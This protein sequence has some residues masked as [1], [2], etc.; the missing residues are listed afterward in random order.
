MI[1]VFAT[2][3]ALAGTADLAEG[4]P[5]APPAF[6]FDETE[7]ATL[8]DGGTVHRYERWNDIDGGVAAIVVDAPEDVVWKHILDYDRYV[9]FMPYVTASTLD[10]TTPGADQTVYDCSM[11]LTTKG[12]VTRYTVR[13]VHV[14]PQGYMTF[15]MLPLAGN[16]LREATGY[17]RVEPWQDDPTRT[18][19][20]YRIDIDTAWYVPAFV[21]N[22]AAD[23]GLP[24]VA[25]LIA[26]QAEK[27]VGTY[28]PE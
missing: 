18:V 22:K 10:E 13:N 15:T 8:D 28:D 20:A 7:R 2:A 9:K 11:E 25:A 23:R 5:V 14:A 3:A 24:T 6:A 26:K 21:K 1:L 17:W 4:E 27:E 12:I 16:P 19:M